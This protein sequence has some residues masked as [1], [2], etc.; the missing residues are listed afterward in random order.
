MTNAQKQQ[1]A[2]ENLTGKTKHNDGGM[3][4][5]PPELWSIDSEHDEERLFTNLK[6]LR[7]HLTRLTMSNLQ[8]TS[9]SEEVS[10]LANLTTLILSENQFEI[11]P[12]LSDIPTLEYLDLSS[13]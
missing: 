7:K 9:L 12:D 1:A 4:V 6:V 5:I 2:Y 3:L 8:M 10:K 13:N 11:L